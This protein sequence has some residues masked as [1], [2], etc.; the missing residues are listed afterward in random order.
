[1]C[2]YA[3][4][5]YKDHFACFT[6]RKTFKHFLYGEA[7]YGRRFEGRPRVQRA[8][9]CPRCRT[10]MADVG[11]DFKAPRKTDRKQWLKAQLLFEGVGAFSGCG[12]GR[13]PRPTHLRDVPAFIAQRCRHRPN[14]R[15]FKRL[16]Q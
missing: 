14:P 2:R 7:V 1:M 5:T 16:S 9:I 13:E 11:L 10:P 6:C 12:C 15:P 4:H 3:F 8:A